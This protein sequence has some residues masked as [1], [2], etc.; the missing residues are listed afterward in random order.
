[1]SKLICPALVAAV[2]FMVTTAAPAI[3]QQIKRGPASPMT[4]VSGASTFR[5]YCTPCHGVGGRGDGPAAKA[6]AKPP[7]DLTQIAKLNKGK[8]DADAVRMAIT[9]DTVIAA[10]GSREMPMWGPVFRAVDGNAAT[11]VRLKNLVTYVQNFQE[12]R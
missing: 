9:G 4:D 12:K 11:D 10:H 6:L 5:A 1:M 8:F 2:G 3:G 7:A